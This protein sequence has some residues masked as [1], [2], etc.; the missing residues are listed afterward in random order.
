[1]AL[2]V[3][4]PKLKD[5]VLKLEESDMLA[6]EAISR[7]GIVQ[8]VDDKPHFIHR[9]FAEYYVADFLVTQLNKETRFVLEVLNVSFKIL[10]GADNAVIRFLP[11]A[12]LLNT[13]KSKAIKEYGKQIYEIW[14]VK[15]SYTL[16]EI[17]KQK[18]TREKL[19]EVLH[20]AAEEDSANKIDFF[21]VA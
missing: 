17:K 4:L 19:Q 18:L 21:L 1:L 6:P 2:E 16:F 7:I 15:Q 14:K 5:T 8:Y 10:L 12:L 20:Q 11:D 9:T 13:E 3:L